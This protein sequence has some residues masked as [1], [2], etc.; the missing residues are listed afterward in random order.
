MLV[1]SIEH[2]SG[3]VRYQIQI[4]YGV[5]LALHSSKHGGGTPVNQFFIINNVFQGWVVVEKN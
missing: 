5:D 2:N 3:I 1:L 4:N